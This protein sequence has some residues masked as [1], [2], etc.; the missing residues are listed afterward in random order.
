MFPQAGRMES[1]SGTLGRRRNESI[2]EVSLGDNVLRRAALLD[3]GAKPANK[4]AECI[5]LDCGIPTEH[6]EE[7][8]TSY[9]FSRMLGEDGQQFELR[10]GQVDLHS[11][12]PDSVH[13]DIDDEISNANRLYALRLVW[14]SNR[15][16]EPSAPGRSGGPRLLCA[17]ESFLEGDANDLRPLSDAK[18]PEE[19]LQSSL[20]GS[21]A[22]LQVAGNLL[23][24]PAP[25]HGRQHSTLPCR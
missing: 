1:L 9:Q 11:A 22:A 15:A 19:L 21:F 24:C 6:L 18:L 13:G 5:P 8:R 4:N 12:D 3:F 17:D 7:S 16:A 2:T 25:G 20:D 14:Q 10:R 23:A